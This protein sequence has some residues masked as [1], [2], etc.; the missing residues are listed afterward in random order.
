MGQ[1]EGSPA[2]RAARGGR[3]VQ[4]SYAGFKLPTLGSCGLIRPADKQQVQIQGIPLVYLDHTPG[5]GENI[6]FPVLSSSTILNDVRM[7]HRPTALPSLEQVGSSPLQ[8]QHILFWHGCISGG[9]GEE[10]R[11]GLLVIIDEIC[12]WIKN[13][14]I[15]N[16]IFLPM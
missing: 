5:Q 10:E 16:E 2:S 9:G 6:L 13:F 11:I 14:I 4:D 15:L 7:Q 1:R 8:V 12:I 3:S